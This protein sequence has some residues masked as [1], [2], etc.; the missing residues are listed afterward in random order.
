M[1]MRAQILLWSAVGGAVVGAIAA[2]LLVG[3]GAV[4]HLLLPAAPG[5]LLARAAPVAV[6]V[7]TVICVLAGAVLGYLEGRLKL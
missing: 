1:P 2:A 4:L 7:L 5:R 6:P 3:A